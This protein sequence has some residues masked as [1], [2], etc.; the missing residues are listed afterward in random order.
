MKCQGDD[1]GSPAGDLK[2]RSPAMRSEMN[3]NRPEEQA[4]VIQGRSQPY[5]RLARA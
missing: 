5:D 4:G 1:L 2:Q 3:L